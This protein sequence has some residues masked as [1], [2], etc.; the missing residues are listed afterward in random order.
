MIFNSIILE[1]RYLENKMLKSWCDWWKTISDCSH[2]Q[3]LEG[4]AEKGLNKVMKGLKVWHWGLC[5][6]YLYPQSEIV[7]NRYLWS[8]VKSLSCVRFFATPWTVAHQAPWSMG[9]SRHEYW[10]G[11][12]FPSPGIFP[13]QG[14]NPGLWVG[15]IPTLFYDYSTMLQDKSIIN[16]G[17]IT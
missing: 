15:K 17:N 2:N 1:E 11:L 14:L 12:S 5:I 13:T 3:S 4:V 7:K 9:F 16:C 10:S 6:I 8:E